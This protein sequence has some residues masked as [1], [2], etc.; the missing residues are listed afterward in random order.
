MATT[1]QSLF[2]WKAS[3][4]QFV[5]RLIL[6][7]ITSLTIHVLCF[8]IFQVQEPKARRTLPQ[9]F[10]AVALTP[11]QPAARAILKQIEDYHSAYSGTLLAG[12]SLE[13]PLPSLGLRANL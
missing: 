7:V 12:S 4:A 2:E 8:Y 9:T 6:A 1:S 10:R 13:M 3:S 11:D 5:Q